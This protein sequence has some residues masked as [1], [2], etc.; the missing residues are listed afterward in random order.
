MVWVL[1]YYH[2]ALQRVNGNIDT[3]NSLSTLCVFWKTKVNNVI[4]INPTTSLD[5]THSTSFCYDIFRGRYQMIAMI[6]A[7]KK[8][9]SLPLCIIQR[10]TL[11]ALL[12][13]PSIIW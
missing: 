5:P 10:K 7:P 11:L 8:Q 12:P 2:P 4:M 3:L 1:N 13:L 9:P 6:L